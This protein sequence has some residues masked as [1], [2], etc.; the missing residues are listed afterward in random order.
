MNGKRVVDGK[1]Y[2]GRRGLEGWERI[3]VNEERITR[4]CGILY[5]LR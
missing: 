5:E 3:V 1:D 4:M 2:D